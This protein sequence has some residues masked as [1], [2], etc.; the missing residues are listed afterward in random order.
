MVH[1]LRSCSAR[2]QSGQDTDTSVAR[3]T[4]ARP[5]PAPARCL[6]P[7]PR[8]PGSHS[9]DLAVLRLFCKWDPAVRERLRWAPSPSER[10]PRE[11]PSG[12]SRGHGPGLCAAERCPRRRCDDG[13]GTNA[14]PGV[15]RSPL[16]CPPRRPFLS[17]SLLSA[18]SHARGSRCPRL[19][20]HPP[21]SCSLLLVLRPVAQAS[22]PQKVFLEEDNDK[23]N[24]KVRADFYLADT[25]CQ[26]LF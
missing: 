23:D 26:G 13:C 2:P 21:W 24:Y 7:G 3:R 11:T 25:R 15:R 18:A 8:K 14:S 17:L 10:R 6:A 12:R 16:P 19:S 5:P 20:T 1:G 9:C 4:H 22:L